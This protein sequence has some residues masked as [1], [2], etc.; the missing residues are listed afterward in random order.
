MTNAIG[1]DGDRH[2]VR[3][4]HVDVSGTV[5]GVGFR[6]FV[7]RLAHSLELAGFVRNDTTGVAIEV[8]GS[9]SR[10]ERFLLALVA[11]AP[12]HAAVR[13]VV[14]DDI[15]PRLDARTFVVAPS[16]SRPGLPASIPADLATCDEC[17]RELFDPSNRRYRYPFINCTE[18]GPR[19]TIA[20]SIPYD[21][22]ATTMASFTMCDDCLREYNDPR[23][24]R[25]HA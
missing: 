18:C 5:Q 10:V 20:R 23:S 15:A 24:R 17:L 14:V 9:G 21:R 2:N 11:D 3:R 1:D 13:R 25:F 19:F 6:P 12:S 16:A 8:E 4:V 22:A 7:Y